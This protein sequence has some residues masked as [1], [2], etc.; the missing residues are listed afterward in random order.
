MTDDI[1]TPEVW[2]SSGLSLASCGFLY[3]KRVRDGWLSPGNEL[4]EMG[5][6]VHSL[7]E[8]VLNHYAGIG[9]APMVER[10]LLSFIRTMLRL[11]GERD[12][13][14]T[15]VET[16]GEHRAAVG[17]Y[18]YEIHPDA[19]FLLQEDG[20]A[21]LESASFKSGWAKHSLEDD[22]ETARARDQVFRELVVLARL[23]P[24]VDK[25]RA[26]LMNLRLGTQT[27]VD[28]TGEELLAEEARLIRLIGEA[29]ERIREDRAVG[30]VQCA[31]C[32]VAGECPIRRQVEARQ[33]VRVASQE[34][35]N[36]ALGELLVLNRLQ[37]AYKEA[38]KLWALSNPPA[39]SGGMEY[40][41]AAP[42]NPSPKYNTAD[43]L[44]EFGAEVVAAYP[45]LS[46]NANGIKG[47]IKAD[48]SKKGR[49]T[50]A[51]TKVE[52]PTLPG[53]AARFEKI[54]FP[55]DTTPEWRLRKKR[56][57]IEAGR[58]RIEP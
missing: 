48:E 4:S 5:T 37:E 31:T 30:G 21:I 17:P 34:G 20:A 42:E 19:V 1:I 52:Y 3:N 33:V 55:P 14:A 8:A 35:A 18:V 57:A 15:L 27:V 38:L 7:C 6:R 2:R 58:E 29:E 47:A 53:A 28:F 40:S 10:D 32:H 46:A 25:F 22:S 23:Y 16:E 43:I 26:R 39:E 56:L 50:F 24:N 45:F 12:Y 49:Q 11:F 41:L 36:Q 9:C 44:E 13:V 51:D 54:A